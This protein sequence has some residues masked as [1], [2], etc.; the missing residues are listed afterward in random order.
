MTTPEAKAADQA[1]RVRL[2]DLPTRLTHWAL[3]L[4]VPFSWWTHQAGQMSWH[5]YSGYSVL[6]LLVFRLFWGLA[7]GS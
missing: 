7:G 4:L 1:I 3:V 6:A 5:R 2:W